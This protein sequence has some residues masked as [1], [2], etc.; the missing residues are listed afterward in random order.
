MASGSATYFDGKS[1]L[2]QSVTIDTA[3]T[4]LRIQSAD[5]TLLAEWPYAELQSF[6]APEGTL[7]L[8]RRRNPLLARLE[9][10]D[11]A[12]AA[13][14][15]QEATTID[16]S[17]LSERRNRRKVVA[18]TFAATASLV[19]VAV[20]GLPAIADRLAPLVPFSVEYRFGVALDKQI[21]SLLDTSR[22]NGKPFECGDADRE[23]AGRAVLDRLIQR[24]E[25]AADLPI[26][27]KAVVVRRSEA[28]A[29]ALPGGHIYVFEGLIERARNADELAGVIAHEIGHVAHRDGTRNVLQAA[30]LSFLFGMLLGDFTGGGVVIIAAKTLLQNASS[31]EVEAAADLYGLRLMAKIG[32]DG[33]AL[34]DIL[35]RIGGANEPGMKI[36]LDHP[37]TKARVA[38]IKAAATPRGAAPLLTPD[39]WLALTRICG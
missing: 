14:I 23:R 24:M 22:R 28:N 9:I 16:R 39:E 11:A 38:T 27:L 21:R 33:A 2:R 10:R 13:A 26:Q 18:W 12:L 4:A 29:I 3:P 30:G 35:A 20:F 6:T 19:L 37:E 15:D 7:R 31:R 17:G 1:S 8:G 32:G 34:G 25:K 36:L 5:G